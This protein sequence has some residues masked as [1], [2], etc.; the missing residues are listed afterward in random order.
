MEA[1]A[2]RHGGFDGVE[3]ADK[4]AMAV[5]LHAAADHDAIEDVQGREPRLGAGPVIV[6]RL[7]G[8]VA[9]G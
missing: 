5:A 4:C 2:G 8:R 7:S 9:E 1:L 3:E 6:A